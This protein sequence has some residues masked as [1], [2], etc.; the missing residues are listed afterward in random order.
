MSKKLL[1]FYFMQKLWIFIWRLNPP[2][3]W[4]INIINK[5]LKENDISLVF[6]GSANII[7]DKNPFTFEERKSFLETIFIGNKSL[8]IDFL[9]DVPDD[10]IWVEKLA[11]KIKK[12]TENEDIQITFYCWDL[13]NDYAI[14]VIKKY[15]EKLQLKNI[16]FTEVSRKEFLNKNYEEVSSTKVRELL[17]NW[18]FESVKDFIPSEIYEKIV[19]DFQKKYI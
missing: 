19:F 9:D 15:L 10:E 11:E 14:L 16:S 8:K 7:D 2:H 4:H 6:F 12:Y 3:I 18:D 1:I 13:E 17:K 5:S